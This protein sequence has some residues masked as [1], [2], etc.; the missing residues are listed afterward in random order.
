[1]GAAVTRSVEVSAH[2]VEV[3]ADTYNG[4]DRTLCGMAFELKPLLAT[5]GGIVTCEQCKQLIA[6]AQDSFTPNFRVRA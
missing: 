3:H 6:Y 5:A 4:D 2:G 1:M